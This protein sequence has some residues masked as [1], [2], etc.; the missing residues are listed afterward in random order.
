MKCHETDCPLCCEGGFKD[1][2]CRVSFDLHP[3]IRA[4]IAGEWKCEK[5]RHGELISD[6]GAPQ[7]LYECRLSGLIGCP[8]CA[9]WQAK[10]DE[11]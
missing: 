11:R 5:C 9:G 7:D 3:I 8:P 10:E 6:P 1:D 2:E 4:M